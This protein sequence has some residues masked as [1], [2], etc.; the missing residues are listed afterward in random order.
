MAQLTALQKTS[1]S[2]KMFKDEK[3]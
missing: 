2:E 3:S 1:V